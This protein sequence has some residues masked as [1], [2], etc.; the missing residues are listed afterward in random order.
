MFLA[1]PITTFGFHSLQRRSEVHK[2][3]AEARLDTPNRGEQ[4]LNHGF[5][6]LQG[7]CGVLNQHPAFVLGTYSTLGV[8][9]RVQS[10]VQ[11]S[12]ATARARTTCSTNF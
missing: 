10:R 8:V 6:G 1:E 4:V 12:A 11:S 9:H 7:P 2:R 3:N 5:K